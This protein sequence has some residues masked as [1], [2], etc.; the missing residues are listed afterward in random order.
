MKY[1]FSREISTPE[2]IEVFTCVEAASFDEAQKV[3]T[4]GIY[5]RMLELETKYGPRPEYLGGP[6]ASP[7]EEKTEVAPAGDNEGNDSPG[8]PSA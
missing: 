5:E 3:V 8:S 6:V 2:G 1:T 7:Q 4:K